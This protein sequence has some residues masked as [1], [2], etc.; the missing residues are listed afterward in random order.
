M[1]CN[2][3]RL[4]PLVPAGDALNEERAASSPAMAALPI[5]KSLREQSRTPMRFSGPSTL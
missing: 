1:M 4:L 2:T 3:L 5:R